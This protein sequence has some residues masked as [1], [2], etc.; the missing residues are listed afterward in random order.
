MHAQPLEA[1]M[2]HL[3]GVVQ[4]IG[5]RLNSIDRRLDSIDGR[6]AQVD[7]RFAQID[8]RFNWLIGIVVG[9]WITTILT[10]SSTTR[11]PPPRNRVRDFAPLGLPRRRHRG[12]N[13]RIVCHPSF[14][15]VDSQHQV[16]LP[17]GNRQ[18]VRRRRAFRS[19][20]RH[21]ERDRAVLVLL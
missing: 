7:A 16:E 11:E 4:Q 15:A 13:V 1:R 9:T 14:G 10:F 2:A 8:T 3:E 12:R 6:F 18:P 19:S 21:I 17:S 5:E 20:L